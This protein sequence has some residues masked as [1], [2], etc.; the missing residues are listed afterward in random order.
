MRVLH[1]A[2][3]QIKRLGKTRVNWAQKLSY[4][5]IKN[6]HFTL[7]FSDRDMATFFAPLKIRDL[8]KSKANKLLLEA[9]ANFR[10]DLIIAGHC[11]M[12][13]NETLKEARRIC[14]NATIVHCNLD[15]LFMP[16]NIAKIRHRSEVVDAVF[17]STGRKELEIFNDL[18][19]RLYHIP[20]P[21]DPSIECFNN[22]LKAPSELPTDVI[23]CSN[24]NQ[25]TRRLEIVQYLKEQ[26]PQE[27][28]FM[29][30]GSFGT[31]PVW[32]HDYDD[33]LAKSKMAL[34]L[35][36]QEGFY[37][38]SSERMAQL[39]GCG[40]LQFTHSSGKFDEL[41]PDKSLVY[42]DDKQELAKKIVEFRNND[43]MR[44]EWAQRA[45]DFF[46]REMNTRLFSQYIVEASTQTAFSHDYVWAQ[47]IHLDGRLK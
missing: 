44:K 7:D 18:P 14:P 40:I 21:V 5:L 11:D 4:G 46:H 34:N 41:M 27:V 25:M 6:D 26:L 33:A 42:F 15:P 12:I 16:D 29:T 1:I 13:T 30:Y 10:P 17:V 24:S 45:Y 3:Q 39:A 28:N 8:G 43:E 31:P 32:G 37:W 36:R 38:Y 22:A 2:Y 23:F 19:V 47:D 9:I 35:N 20:N